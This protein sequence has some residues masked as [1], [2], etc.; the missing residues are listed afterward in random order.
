QPAAHPVA[1]WLGLALLLGIGGMAAAVWTHRRGHELLGL[2]V[3]GLTSCAVA[4]FAWNHHWV[5]FVPLLVLL[6]HA[7]R[8]TTSQARWWLAP[9]PRSSAAGQCS[10]V[11]SASS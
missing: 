5:W 3:C 6:G 4:P 11:R 1:L 7:A 9:P 2:T 10:M 8:A